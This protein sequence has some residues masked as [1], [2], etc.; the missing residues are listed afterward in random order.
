MAKQSKSITFSGATLSKKDRTITEYA[1]D[2]VRVT[3]I[4]ELLEQ[5]DGEE[6]LTIQIKKTSEATI[7]REDE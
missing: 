6:D 2:S 3:N 7:S 4:D 1:K 5:W